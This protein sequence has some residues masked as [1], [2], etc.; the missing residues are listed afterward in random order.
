MHSPAITGQVVLRMLSRAYPASM[1]NAQLSQRPT[2]PN[3]HFQ[4]SSALGRPPL[5]LS[6]AFWCFG[7]LQPNGSQAIPRPVSSRV[8]LELQGKRPRGG[9]LTLSLLRSRASPLRQLLLKSWRN[10]DGP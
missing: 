10:I 7:G 3:L 2:V 8:T 9:N 6:F 1:P 4:F 5:F